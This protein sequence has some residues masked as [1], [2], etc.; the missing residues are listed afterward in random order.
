MSEPVSAPAATR[1]YDILVYG[2]T[3][4]GVV[5]AVSAAADGARVALI[6]PGHHV[7]GM[8]SGGL[9][10]S[11]LGQRDVVGGRALAFYES[12]ARHYGV[13]TWGWVGPE[14]HAAES[15]FRDWL[16][17]AGVDVH[18]G[19]RPSTVTV[20]DGRVERIT[21]VGD[22]LFDAAVFVDA[23]YEGDLM[24]GAGVSYAVGREDRRKHGESWAGRQPFR[25]GKHDFDVVLSP[26]RDGTEGESLPLVHDRP[27]VGPGDGDGAVQG[28]GFRVCL[29]RNPDNRMPFP[30][31]DELMDLE[32]LR[33][34]LAAKGDTL[35]AGGLMG[36]VPNL[37]GDKCDVNSIGPL[38][39][40]LLDGSNWAYPEADPTVREA[41]RER[42]L[43]Y[44]QNFLYYLSH[45]DEVPPTVRR[46]LQE[47][48]LPR[49]EFADTGGWPHQLYV[50][51]ARRMCGEYLM[52]QHDLTSRARKYDA[53]GMGSYHIDVR[54]VQR[55]WQELHLHPRL[56]PAV[57]NE[58]YISVPVE[59]Y[60]IP[61]RSLV[62]KY[63]ECEN[64]I[65][66]VCVSASHVA[67]ASIRMEPQ[68]MILGHAAGIAA[69]MAARANRAV[70]R[71]DV[72][73][74]QA[75]LRDERQVLARPS[76]PATSTPT[77]RDVVKS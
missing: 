41:I 58:G 67:F 76:V 20:R 5:A 65:V 44:A 36:L 40:N 68:Y 15:I 54:H 55:T 38:S 46:D 33:R 47:W 8:V 24:A 25:P 70:Q 16:E 27:V 4:G 21:T 34:Y 35:R 9:G 63:H 17:R 26:F 74:L 13:P 43:R 60:Q 7:G 3:A 6:E 62:P 14:P 52:T 32:L 10:Y 19:R 69:S 77:V 11:D 12:V 73:A 72:E 22:D 49:D 31:P 37:P 29:T 28:Y 59:A 75:R 42:H 71:I 61:Y 51:E 57:A 48:G 45:S 56:V 66:P 50:R 23:S 1:S 30:E 2:A 39:L 64:L 18:F 53:V